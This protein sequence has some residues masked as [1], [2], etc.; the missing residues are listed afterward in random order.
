MRDRIPGLDQ[1]L[2]RESLALFKLSP[3]PGL[4]GGTDVDAGGA[5]ERDHFAVH[6][7]KYALLWFVT[8]GLAS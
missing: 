7:H 6:G 5:C 2:G 8:V 1:R 3:D 4:S